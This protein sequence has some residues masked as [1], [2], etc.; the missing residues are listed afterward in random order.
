MT[1]RQ[2][3]FM[4]EKERYRCDLC[5]ENVDGEVQGRSGGASMYMIGC[6][7][8]IC[9]HVYMSQEWLS[10][11]VLFIFYVNIAKQRQ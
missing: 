6:Q 11:Q 3:G 4:P 2:Y 7:K 5:F 8:R 1:E 9:D 10:D